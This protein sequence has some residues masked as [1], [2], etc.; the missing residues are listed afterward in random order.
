MAMLISLRASIFS[1]IFISQFCHVP[2]VSLEE[3]RSREG[4][5]LSLIVDLDHKSF[6]AFVSLIVPT[7]TTDFRWIVLLQTIGYSGVFEIMWHPWDNES[8]IVCITI[9]VGPK[10]EGEYCI[11]LYIV[12]HYRMT[13]EQKHILVWKFFL[14]IHLSNSWP[15]NI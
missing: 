14:I 9:F 10:F 1:S 2:Y 5:R 7:K 8:V 3:W 6:N 4:P 13:K 11:P 15:W 12:V